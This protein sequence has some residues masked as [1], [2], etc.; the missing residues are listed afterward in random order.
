MTHKRIYYTHRNTT[1]YAQK[2]NVGGKSYTPENAIN[3]NTM[4]I[5]DLPEY[6]VSSD[7][8]TM[9]TLGVMIVILGVGFSIS[10]VI[11]SAIFDPK[12]LLIALPLFLFH[13]FI[14][15]FLYQ[16]HDVNQTC[17]DVVEYLKYRF[18]RK[19]ESQIPAPVE[20]GKTTINFALSKRLAAI[21]QQLKDQ[22]HLVDDAGLPFTGVLERR[23]ERLENEYRAANPVSAKDKEQAT[24]LM[25]RALDALEMRISQA[26]PGP[27]RFT[28]LE[29]FVAHLEK[30][31]TE[32]NGPLN[33]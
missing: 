28:S 16:Y 19:K 8:F 7:V 26:Q 21:R 24:L 9:K 20:P 13:C 12:N 32:R 6:D 3:P 4:K 31:A 25:S 5:P 11:A 15:L 17:D 23:L 2:I 14:L 22:P 33:L 10:T 27:E 30:D 29:G 1:N 18:S